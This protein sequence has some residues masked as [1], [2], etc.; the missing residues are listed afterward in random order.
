MDRHE[1]GIAQIVVL[2][3][4]PEAR[5]RLAEQLRDALPHIF[6][7]FEG[8]ACQPFVERRAARWPLLQAL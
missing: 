7:P 5:Y 6:R 4:R 8:K 2:A 1:S 3:V